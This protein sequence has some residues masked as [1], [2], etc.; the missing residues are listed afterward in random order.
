MNKKDGP[1]GEFH[2]I[3]K[4][5]K[6]KTSSGEG[7]NHEFDTVFKD[8]SKFEAK[9]SGAAWQ[10]VG[11]KQKDKFPDSNVWAWVTI[12][13]H[14]AA[15]Y[16]RAPVKRCLPQNNNNTG[17]YYN[18]WTGEE[19]TD[20]PRFE[21]TTH[22]QEFVELLNSDPSWEEVENKYKEQLLKRPEEMT[23]GLNVTTLLR[24]SR[25]AG[26]LSRVVSRLPNQESITQSDNYKNFA[27]NVC[28]TI[29]HITVEFVQKPYRTA[30]LGVFEYRKTKMEELASEYPDNVLAL[31]ENEYITVFENKELMEEF[32]NKL[33]KLGFFI[34]VRILQD[35]LINFDRN[36]P[37]ARRIP[38]VLNQ[39][40]K[41][42]Y[43]ETVRDVIPLGVTPDIDIC[44]CCQMEQGSLRDATDILCNNC[45]TLRDCSNKLLKLAGW[46]E[47]SVAWVKLHLDLKA[48]LG[49]IKELHKGFLRT[50]ARN[51]EQLELEMK[52]RFPVSLSVI[53]DFLSDYEN[54]IGTFYK[55]LLEIFTDKNIE[56]VEEKSLWCV[57]LEE[58]HEIIKVI[59]SY[60]TLYKVSFPKIF[61]SNFDNPISL[62][63]SISNVKHPF[64]EHW[65][66]LESPKNEVDI[67]VVGSGRA[68]F[69][70]KHTEEVLNALRK[71]KSHALHRLEAIAEISPALARVALKERA[72][73]QEESLEPIAQLTVDKASLESIRT[74]IVLM[75]KEDEHG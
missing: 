48:L 33:R 52:E 57:K 8:P 39:V 65:K 70:L 17:F 32:L 18:L 50:C 66:F 34:R 6:G 26:K 69:K 31:I 16:G 1:K 56:I 49:T 11:H 29:L 46:E 36:D 63:L 13:D 55:E 43:G 28:L 71:T 51:K 38:D 9:I 45:F 2:D 72:T 64:F 40:P 41:N 3:G 14:I 67:Q 22:L 54:F 62:A 12:G 53:S 20:D 4:L 25:I 24:H 59:D 47:G 23:K 44:E 19:V 73:T 10:A 68:H 74:L 27:E 61:E 60:L 75:K 21:H 7:W 58:R 42:W 15:G 37:T 5:L 35:K 30:D